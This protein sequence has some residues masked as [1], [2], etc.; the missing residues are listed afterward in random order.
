MITVLVAA[1]G[2]V[3]LVS[4]HIS[5]KESGKYHNHRGLFRELCRAHQLCWSDQ[6]LLLAVARQQGVAVPARM[7]LEPDRF[8]P[9]R[10]KDLKEEQRSRVAK[11][12]E[13]LFRADE[14]AKS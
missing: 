3:W 9:E 4:R 8:E 13:T 14:D 7:F 10:L 12:H 11:L 5:M 6:R 2:V 1:I